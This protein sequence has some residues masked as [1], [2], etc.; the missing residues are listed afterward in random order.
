MR[1]PN[2]IHEFCQ[3]LERVWS[4]TPDLRFGQL[5]VNVLGVDP[6]YIEDDKALELLQNAKDR[7][8]S[9]RG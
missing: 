7:C 1:D 8:N 3:E 9:C 6:F 5:V 4:K 2:R